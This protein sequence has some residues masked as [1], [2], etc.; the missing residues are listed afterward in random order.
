MNAFPVSQ[1]YIDGALRDAA[2]G[3]IYDN[4]APA[5]GEVVGQAADGSA[6]DMEQAI[7]AARKAFDEG[8]WPHDL[9]LRLRTMRR[10]RDELLARSEANKARIAAES[11]AAAMVMAGPGHDLPIH[12]MDWVLNLAESYDYERE[13]PVSDAMGVASRRIVVREPGGVVAAITPWNMPL[14]IN[15]AKLAPA[16]VAGCTVVLKPA[17]ETPWSAAL[18]GE[19]AEAAG[20]PAGVLNVVTSADKASIGEQLVLD[21]R[22]DIISFTGSTQTGRR[23]MAAAA[24]SLK[25]VFLE[26]GG[27]S[28]NIILDDAPF[29]DALF[30]AATVCYHSGQGCSLPTRLLVPRERQEEAIATVKGIYES[31]PYGDP[32]DPQQMISPLISDMQRDRVLAYIEI[33][34]A[35]GARLV[36]GGEADPVNGGYYVKPTVFADVTNDMRIAQEEIFGPVI[37]IIP[38]DGD[39]DAI[40]IANDSIYGLSGAV[41]SADKQRALAVAR[42]IRT[43]TINVNAANFFGPD[44]PFGGYKHS[45]VGREMGVEGFEEYLQIKTIAVEP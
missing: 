41:Q 26:L 43:G 45:G 42:R 11:G 3:A 16:L 14:Q 32:A 7:A 9:P 30:S 24:Q 37:V 40:R 1:L 5:T 15:L 8:P 6:S 12:F 33:G 34:K 27:K 25:K 13:L 22:I 19:A 39:D 20:F 31:L 38:H 23:I 4:V 2:G 36:T 10:F 35:E 29:P 44:A 17:P 28:A 18:L 21:P